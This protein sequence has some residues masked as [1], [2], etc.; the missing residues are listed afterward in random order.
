MFISGVKKS[1]LWD[2]VNKWN[3]YQEDCHDQTLVIFLFTCVWSNLSMF[4]MLKFIGWAV[5]EKRRLQICCIFLLKI[6]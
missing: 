5:V 6:V 2:S 1:A 3:K 4:S